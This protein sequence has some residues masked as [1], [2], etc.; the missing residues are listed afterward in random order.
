MAP[1]REG[2]PGSPPA[3]REL[4]QLLARGSAELQ[5]ANALLHLQYRIADTL[6]AVSEPQA[7]LSGILAALMEIEGLDSGGVYTADERGGLRLRAHRGLSTLFVDSATSYAPESEHVRL[8]RLGRPVYRRLSNL[9]TTL[10]GTPLREEGLRALAII[11]A[12]HE[13][14]IRAVLNLGSHTVDEIPT[15]ARAM[16]EAVATQVAEVVAAIEAQERL[17]LQERNLESLFDSVDDFL[18]VLDADA[19]IIRVNRVVSERLGYSEEDLLGQSVL[20]VHPEA[21]RAEA[22]RIVVDMLAGRARVCPVPLVTRTGE[23]V[24]VETRVRQGEWSGRPALF[25]VSRDVSEREQAAVELRDERDFARLVMETVAHGLT[26]IDTGGRFVYVNPAYAAMVGHT[27]EE[28]VGRKPADFTAPADLAVLEH[29]H[30]ERQLGRR[31]S[32]ETRLVR[33]DGS[34]VPVVITAAP[35]W[36]GDAVAGAIAVIADLSERKHAEE[37][38]LQLERRVRDAWRHS[39]LG[40]MAGGV[41]HHFNN[42]L[43]VMLGNLELAMSQPTLPG[44]SRSSLEDVARAAERAAEIAGMMLTYVGQR[45]RVDEQ[46]PLSESISRIL[47][48]L[49]PSLPSHV[50]LESALPHEGPSVKVHNRE[51]EQVVVNLVANAVEAIG[52]GPGT[53]SVSL[54]TLPGNE[55]GFDPPRRAE[56]PVASL[57]FCDTGHGMSEE[58]RLRMFDP[59]FTTHMTG[60]GLGLAVALGIVKSREGTITVDSAPGRGTTVRVLLPAAR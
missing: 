15:H 36:R 48:M 56:D 3:D 49:G 45:D 44:P 17:R 51:L 26:V 2:T 52:P 37:T 27:Q 58:T 34:Q 59:F 11:P 30:S 43:T 18:F 50:R 57:E 16:L 28:V 24:P 6:K 55:A 13:G 53:I 20:V 39:S 1:A 60:R 35:W 22:E 32:Y 33:P 8:A 23:L 5:R 31:S 38:R 47:S 19:R 7:V 12:T 41:A 14:R 46:L 25:G 4:E 42:L 10:V 29:A 9:P 54:R 21:R 40:A